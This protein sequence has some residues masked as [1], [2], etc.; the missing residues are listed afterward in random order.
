ME[1]EELVTTAYRASFLHKNIERLH[2]DEDLK[3]IFRQAFIWIWKDEDMHTIYTRGALLK[4]GNYS[5]KFKTF[6]SQFQGFIGGWSG[7]IIQHLSWKEAPVSLAL[8][9]CILSFGK[10]SGKIPKEIRNELKHGSFKNFCAFNMDAENTAR[11][12]WER[13]IALAKKDPRYG[14]EHLKDFQRI[15]FDE[16]RHENVF[17]IIFENLTQED[18]LIEGSVKE[19]IISQ[20]KNVS[21]YFLPI[22]F[23]NKTSNPVGSGGKVWVAENNSSRNKYDFF[24]DELKKTELVSALT[25]KAKAN[26]QAIENL[27]IVIKVSFSMGYNKEDLSPIAD[28]VL[29][30]K[31]A[32]YIYNLGFKTIKVIDIDSIYTNFYY[33][34]SVAELARYFQ[35]ESE[36]YQIVNA[37]EELE[38]HHFT[39]GIG[40]YRVSKTWKDSEFRIN[41]AK[42]KSHPSELALLSISNLEWLTGSAREFVFVDRTVNRETTTCMLLDDFPPNF[43]LVEAYD[44][45]PIGILGVMGCKRPINPRRFYFG[46][47]LLSVDLALAKHLKIVPIPEKTSLRNTLYWF[48]IESLDYKIEGEDSVIKEWK[49]PTKNYFWAFLGLISLPVYQLLSNKGQLFV[50]KMDTA[51]FPAKNKPGIISVLRL[52]NRKI[53][54]LP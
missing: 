4:S 18:K 11:V 49:S 41:F 8:A 38:E 3:T 45:V 17:R 16:T 46:T 28:A 15:I 48:G 36:Y 32:E 30:K 53:T 23:R 34:R 20:L 1:R 12:C 22:K 50:P 31:F 27:K 42:I 52:V 9:K 25:Q 43:T 5:H 2:V 51:N 37:T 29:L 35:F 21:D 24:I 39:R 40:N 26:N 14:E 10:I 6:I 7:S 19:D 13:I 47:D 33:N 54:N 44:L